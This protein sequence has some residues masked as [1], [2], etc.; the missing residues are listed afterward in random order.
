MS[1]TL[2][3]GPLKRGRAGTFNFDI[4]AASPAHII[5]IEDVPQRIRAVLGGETVLDTRRAKVLYESNIPGQ[6][7]IPREDV[8]ADLLTPTETSTH[9][10]FKGD[11]SY[12]TLKIGD[13]VETDMVWAYPQSPSPENS[14]I[15]QIKGM[16]AFY[17]GRLDAWFEEDEQV[18][19]HPRD[20]YHRCDARRC[21]DHVTVKVNGEIVAESSRAVKL[22]ET[23]ISPRY[24]VPVGDVKAEVLTASA[25]ST[26]CAYK[27]TAS[28]FAVAGVA[29]AAWVYQQPFSEVASIAG[30]L[31]FAGEG[32]EVSV[33]PG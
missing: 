27:G 31:S 6:W 33:E 11:A 5:Y 32:V 26:V 8:R 30:L 14:V 15:E 20:P 2:G 19:G 10:P 17:F 24:Y 7:Y 18:F 22:F 9:C 1:L 16:Q 3:S 12:W 23:S 28:Y 29:D 25:T 4:D 21:S 13:R